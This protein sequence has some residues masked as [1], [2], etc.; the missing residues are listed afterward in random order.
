MILRLIHNV[1]IENPRRHASESVERLR[2][3][4]AEGTKATADPKRQGFYDLEDDGRV[5][6]IYVSPVSG[7]VVLLA[8]WLDHETASPIPQ[9]AEQCYCAHA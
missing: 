4:L 3:L 8:T 6:Y 2:G 9:P 5:F 1:T 7:R